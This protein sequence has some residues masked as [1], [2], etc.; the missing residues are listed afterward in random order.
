VRD[1]IDFFP[2][3]FDVKTLV[4]I[5]PPNVY[6]YR[7]KSADENLNVVFPDL[8]VATV[9]NY[10]T[11]VDTARR[12][13]EAPTKQL[14]ASGE[15]LV[16]LGEVLS[17]RTQTKL[18][19]LIG[20]AATQD[21]SP[22]ILL[23]GVKPGTAPLVLGIV[24]ATGDQVFVTSLNLSLDGVEQ[25]F[26]HINLIEKVGG[27][28]SASLP[29]GAIFGGVSDRIEDPV[30]FPDN[31]VGS[32][33][34][35]VFLHGY[36]VN[37][38]Q[39]RGFYSEM[40][41][42][43]Y[44]SGLQAK[45]WGVSWY[46]FETQGE[47]PGPG[48]FTPNF[49][50]NVE[51]ARETADFLS[52]A[53][54]LYIPP[55]ENISLAAHSLGN[56]V[57]AGFLSEYYGKNN[58]P[59]WSRASATISKVFMIDAAVALEAFSGGLAG[60]N[61]A[62]GSEN[63]NNRNMYHPDWYDFSLNQS[64]FKRDLWASDWYRLFNDYDPDTVTDKREL[65]TWRDRYSVMTKLCG[66]TGSKPGIGCYNFFSSGEEVLATHETPGIDWWRNVDD[67]PNLIEGMGGYYSFALQERLKGR[68][69]RTFPWVGVYGQNNSMTLQN[70][71]IA[72]STCG[73]WGVNL[74]YSHEI[75]D[76]VTNSITPGQLKTKPFFRVEPPLSDVLGAT[77]LETLPE[78]ARMKLLAD[79]IPAL[80]LPAG[81]P[82]GKNLSSDETFPL[83][84]T[85]D[86]QNLQNDWP[87][88]RKNNNDLYWKHSDL[89][90]V[91]YPFVKDLFDRLSGYRRSAP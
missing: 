61:S 42:R 45:F 23:E 24:D 4:E 16:T 27:P 37:G 76:K 7:L 25:M 56:A 83:E 15:F 82:G 21:T 89:E 84:N 34:N 2:V 10:L 58:D 40:F 53:L 54:A 62:G 90:D 29:T 1:L 26:R 67:N 8:S 35:F 41:K 80:T 87:N 28:S 74:E 43:L 59:F 68:M 9:E 60:A 12:L 50:I 17:G 6:S 44:W 57:V 18:D 66:G 51:H 36:N 69:K 20:A 75:Y 77:T 85:V 55:G 19:E 91:A 48:R 13:A 22:V 5:F 72:G 63:T 14:R 88:V 52:P 39:A 65:L 33:D 78:E 70:I 47:R 79:C 64:I 49:H 86:M 46:G 38:Q 32:S 71:F 30:N 31:E 11:D 73:G 81:G 3:A